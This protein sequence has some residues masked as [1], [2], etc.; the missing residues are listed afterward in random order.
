MGKIF[1]LMGKSSSGKD[2]IFKKILE[3]KELKLN[4]IILY[5]TRPIRAGE[6]DGVEY[7]FVTEKEFGE[8]EQSGRLIEA[9]AYDTVHGIWR[10]F[11]V[12]DGQVD[13]ENKDYLVIGTLESYKR[14]KAYFGEKNLV[15]V[16]IDLD[17]GIRLLR[18]LTREQE[19]EMPRYAE[20]C[21]RFLADEQDFSEEKLKE[22]GIERKFENDSL[23]RCMEEITEYIKQYIKN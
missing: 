6:T 17:D 15:P 9:R 1:Y 5:T 22:A 7:F 8:F 19:Q 16:Y 23:E 14:M 18:G 3:N 21:R 12:D 10:Y 2:T 11:T 13:F 4:T 20:M